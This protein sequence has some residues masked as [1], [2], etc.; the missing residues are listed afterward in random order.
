MR[1]AKSIRVFDIICSSIL[2][3]RGSAPSLR[4]VDVTSGDMEQEQNVSCHRA[5]ALRA[6]YE[7]CSILETVV[8]KFADDG[9]LD[10]S[11]AEHF[12]QLLKEWSEVLP[13]SLRQRPQKGDQ[14]LQ[15][16]PGYRERMIANIHVAGTY[17]FGIILVT[18]Q[19]LIQHVMPQLRGH[20]SPR[21]RAGRHRSGRGSGRPAGGGAGPVAELS[22]ACTGAA[23]Y[24]AQ[25]CREAVDA[26]VFRGNMCIVK[27]WAFAAGLVLGFALLAD[28]P[29]DA[30]AREAFR[31]S[32]HVLSAL[33]RLS[34]QARQYHGILSA[35]SDAIEKYRRQMRR[36]RNESRVPFVEQILSYDVSSGVGAGQKDDGASFQCGRGDDMMVDTGQ[37]HA[38]QQNPPPPPPPQGI[39][40]PGAPQFPAPGFGV[41]GLA[42]G[43]GAAFW[44]GSDDLSSTSD[45][46]PDH[47]PSPAD[48]E[49]MLRI[50]WD[51]YTMSFDDPMPAMC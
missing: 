32:Q 31:G 4:S 25:M 42:V 8:G 7:S 22:R 37:A 43:E 3:R 34:A 11:S 5:L 2:G 39:D 27:A 23:T 36:E 51:G 48:N 33:G 21:A 24:L 9:A 20:A 1:V 6:T 15:Q 44:N 40:H 28:D 49:L 45:F 16:H 47:W 14:S 30:D 41:D 12:L 50:L 19:F 35:F 18:R 38:Q 17:Y 26:G 10:P 29:S 46:L 13:V